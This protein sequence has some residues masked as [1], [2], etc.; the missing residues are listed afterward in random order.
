M[1]KE[2]SHISVA[3]IIILFHPSEE[4]KRN[5]RRLADIYSGAIVDNSQ[6]RSFEQDK[7]GLMHYI[8]I[9]E[10][11]GI[12]KAQNI[13][14]QYILTKTEASHIV[15]LDQDSSVPDNYPHLI[16][17]TFE[18][19]RQDFPNLAFL[20]PR[21]ENKI[22][23][24]EYKSIIHK[25]NAI[26]SDFI[27]KREIISSGG[28]TTRTII[29][30]IGLNNESMFIDYIDFEWCWRANNMGYICG[31]ARNIKIQHMVGQNTIYIGGYTIIISAPIRYYY[32]YRNYIW[33]CHKKY[34]P[35]QWKINT[36]V[37]MIAR[38]IYFPIL[39]KSG[40]KCWRNMIKG[41]FT[42]ITH[43]EMV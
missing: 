35:L 19:I 37:K 3:L 2:D 41:I 14:I 13:G 40:M 11:V 38:L 12:A 36:G 20:G 10:N 17:Q 26:T 27:I 25:A 32:Q 18:R 31:I 1:N 30:Q 6:V 16:A 33:L 43:K 5:V 29:K 24:R 8:P 34:V 22:S 9:N 39:I 42:G 7:I 15:F 23:G 4:E 21:T 28:C